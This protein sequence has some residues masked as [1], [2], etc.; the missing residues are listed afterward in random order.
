MRFVRCQFAAA[1]AVPFFCQHHDGTAF[2]GFIRKRR[3]LRRVGQ[4]SLGNSRRR[5]KLRGLAIAESDG[6]GLIE[7]QG[8]H[9]A[10]GFDGP[11]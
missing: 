6:A 3:Q 9:V 4:L 11:S 1:Q 10:R 7:K 5:D 2:R 8:V